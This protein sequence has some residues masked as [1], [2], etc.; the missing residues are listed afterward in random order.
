ME[1]S[2]AVD[3]VRRPALFKSEARQPERYLSQEERR[4]RQSA[5]ETLF[6]ERGRPRYVW[7]KEETVVPN[8]VASS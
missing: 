4:G 8:K 7:G 2:T 5:T 6:G 3:R 1:L